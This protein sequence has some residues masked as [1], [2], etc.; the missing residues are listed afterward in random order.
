VFRSAW[1]ALAEYV[2]ARTTELLV[3]PEMPFARWFAVSREFDDEVW[4][5]AVTEHEQWLGRLSDLSP[6]TVVCSRPVTR[7][8]RR[9]N[10]GFAWSA[11]D[12][13]RAIHDKRFLPNEAGYWEAQWYERGE[14]RFEVAFAAQA[15]IGMLICTEQ[16]SF[17]HAQQYGRDGAQ[18]IVTPRATG[19]QTVEKWL[20]GGRAA[21]IAAGAFGASSNRTADEH[22]G[23][24]G[25]GGWIVGPDGDV[26]ARTTRDDPFATAEI[27]LADADRA[28]TTYPRYA[29]D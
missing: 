12:G 10:E 18:V 1:A 7:D 14:D 21:A 2:R 19:R 22:G 25:G 11:A 3:L 24:F 4:Q 27:D 6:A 5:A 13:Y 29:M 15:R 23:D 28:R 8:G 17:A 20:T 26:L 16:W 9:L